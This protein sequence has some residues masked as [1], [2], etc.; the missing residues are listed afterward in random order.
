VIDPAIPTRLTLHGDSKAMFK[1]A[2]ENVSF[3]GCCHLPMAVIYLHP[4]VAVAERGNADIG[5][6]RVHANHPAAGA[7]DGVRDTRPILHPNMSPALRAQQGLSSGHQQICARYGL[8]LDMCVGF[9]VTKKAGQ[10]VMTTSSQTLNSD[11]FKGP[12]PIMWR[13]A[14]PAQRDK[15]N[16]NRL[17]TGGLTRDWA[18]AIAC[19]IELSFALTASGQGNF[20]APF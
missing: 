9:A 7:V 15:L 10:S 14:K 13:D 1:A 8:D 6:V 2:G 5:M 3:T 11:K 12:L 18:Y 17:G 16:A 19:A 20:E 4:L